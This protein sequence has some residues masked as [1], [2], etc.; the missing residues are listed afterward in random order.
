MRCKPAVEMGSRRRTG[1]TGIYVFGTDLGF[2]VS[3]AANSLEYA[4]EIIDLI[5]RAP[6]MAD[7]IQELEKQLEAR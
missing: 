2:S 3:V 5:M 4:E 1:P 7:R 6:E